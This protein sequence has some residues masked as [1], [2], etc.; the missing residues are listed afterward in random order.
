MALSPLACPICGA[1][2]SE[3]YDKHGF[4]CGFCGFERR[5]AV[6]QRAYSVLSLE[7]SFQDMYQ[8]LKRGPISEIYLD[9]QENPLQE[10]YP[11]QV[12]PLSKD[13]A[14]L[15]CIWSDMTLPFQQDLPGFFREKFI[16]LRPGGL[17]YLSTP[18]RQIF[19]RPAALP[20]Q[21]NFFRPKNIMFQLE[22]HGFKMAWRKNRFSAALRIIARKC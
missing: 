11:A 21:I 3:Q 10:K 9:G 6:G 14:A 5:P 4:I 7:Q 13:S 2:I 17:L 20:G 8:I 19:Q 18:V 15:D 22:Q 1:K 12:I 16:Q